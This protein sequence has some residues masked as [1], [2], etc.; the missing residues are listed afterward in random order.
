V[1]NVPVQQI[2]L[3]FERFGV[4]IP[5]E[6]IHFFLLLNTH[7]G[8]GSHPA[9]NQWAFSTGNKR[10]FLG[11]KRSERKANHWSLSSAEVKYE[12]KYTCIAPTCPHGV[13]SDNLVFYVCKLYSTFNYNFNQ[14][15]CKQ[16]NGNYTEMAYFIKCSSQCSQPAYRTLKYINGLNNELGMKE[17]ELEWGTRT[18]WMSL[19]CDS[20]SSLAL[21]FSELKIYYY[22]VNHT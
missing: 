17:M 18:Y 9:S 13:Y 16:Q 3:R 11:V 4:R 19:F 14:S 1:S 15:Y 21:I 6:A 2:G 22:E 20:H 5:A 12:W 8:S 7:T 10:S